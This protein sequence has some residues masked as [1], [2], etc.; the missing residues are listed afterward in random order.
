MFLRIFCL[1]ITLS[2]CPAVSAE[3]AQLKK[4]SFI[5]LWK[6]QAQFA[7]YYVA[8][9]KGLYKAAGLDVTILEGGPENPPEEM[10]AAGTADFGVMWLSPALRRRAEGMKI[11]NISQIVQRSA[12]MLVARKSSGILK[13]QD[14]AGKKVSLWEGDLQL[15]PQAFLRDNGV[16]A[17]IVPQGY[18]VNLF[19]M[20]GVDVISAMWYNEYHTLL[21]AGFN[22]DELSTFFFSD[23]GLN[24]PEDGIYCREETL[25]DAP[26]A[27]AAFVRA[28]LAG[29]R[30]AFE[31]P[32]E[33]L[34][35]VLRYMQTAHVP[36]NR[37]HQRWMLERMKDL[38]LPGNDAAALGRLN[39]N[40]YLRV[41]GELA[42]KGLI[43][44]APA[45][46]SFSIPV[47]DEP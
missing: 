16:Q 7:G 32:D 2:F 34:D 42:R 10:L 44:A 23:Y 12:L 27:A 13:P 39:Q 43:K 11:V 21:N 37:V 8:Y 9:E 29:W 5:P 38:I 4:V 36:A 19:L 31:H 35:I 1:L 47:Q 18:T 24:F 46:D 3:Q 33:T 15:Q 26:Q 40:D 20:G 41:S 45:F 28:S 30:Y 6:P 14:M 17:Q 22:S 25:R